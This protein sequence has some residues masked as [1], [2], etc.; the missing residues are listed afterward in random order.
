MDYCI[1]CSPHPRKRK[2]TLPLPENG[3]DAD[4][5]ASTS[6]Y[7]TDDAEFVHV[8]CDEV[9]KR[10]PQLTSEESTEKDPLLED[11]N[12]QTDSTI[13]ISNIKSEPASTDEDDN[14]DAGR[15]ST[16]QKHLDDGPLSHSISS[17]VFV[18]N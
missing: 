9:S 15:Y 1:Q 5:Q 10:S 8:G 17:R 6:K 2:T 11:S 13:F 14:S 7:Q 4:P 16:T 12:Q 18:S 3:N